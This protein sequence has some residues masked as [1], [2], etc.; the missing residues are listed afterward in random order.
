V[1]PIISSI[2]AA[3][4]TAPP[5][6]ATVH[7]ASTNAAAATTVGARQPVTTVSAL[8]PARTVAPPPTVPPTGLHLLH[9]T[10]TPTVHK[11]RP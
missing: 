10:G 9:L 1:A 2:V 7:V 5:V 4:P 3:T 6:T 11:K 8:T